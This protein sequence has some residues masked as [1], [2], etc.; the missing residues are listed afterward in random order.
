MLD[1]TSMIVTDLSF[2][3]AMLFPDWFHLILKI[4]KFINKFFLKEK[5]NWKKKYNLMESE[6]VKFDS[7]FSVCE[8]C[9]ILHKQE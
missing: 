9:S 8:W 2:N 1:S 5:I 7:G 6:C 4:P 3:E